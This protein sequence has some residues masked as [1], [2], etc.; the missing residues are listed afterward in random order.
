[1]HPPEWHNE[2]GMLY[3]SYGSNMSSRRL[4]RR[5]A[6]ARFVA[7]ARL[8]GHE[9]RFHKIGR[10]GSGKCDVLLTGDHGSLVYGVVFDIPT[11]EKSILD[12]YEGLGAGYDEKRVSLLTDGGEELRALT[13]YATRI[14]PALRP[15]HWY[16]NHVLAGAREHGLPADYIAGI[17]A[18]VT[19]ADPD[20][21]RHALESAIYDQGK[22]S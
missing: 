5:V 4:A 15:F 12:G 9:L 21:A 17:E 10:D 8:P 1:M 19:I 11:R 16:R 22:G 3:F 18:L 6:S 14:D 13:Y 7:V 20:P 2:T